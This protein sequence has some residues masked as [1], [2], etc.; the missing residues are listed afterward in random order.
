MTRQVVKYILNHVY[1][2]KTL[3]YFA[4]T[5][6]LVHVD[7]SYLLDRF[8]GAC[9]PC[10]QA[11]HVVTSGPPNRIVFLIFIWYSSEDSE[12]VLFP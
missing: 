6:V 4:A 7:Q 5:T 9:L 11:A 10:T 3:K 2:L 1:N 8:L 12:L